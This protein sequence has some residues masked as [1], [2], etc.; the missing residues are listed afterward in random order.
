MKLSFFFFLTTV[1]Q[2]T[3]FYI[4]LKSQQ[5]QNGNKRNV[6]KFCVSG[7]SLNINN[8]INHRNID[9]DY[10]MYEETHNIL[11]QTDTHLHSNS[12]N[13]VCVC[14]IL[15]CICQYNTRVRKKERNYL[16]LLAFLHFYRVFFISLY[17]KSIIFTFNVYM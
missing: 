5:K 12:F 2:I 8:N 11:H 14:C 9:D 10:F 4:H 3:I 15:Y 6:C 13:I 1:S 17:L 7:D 16:L